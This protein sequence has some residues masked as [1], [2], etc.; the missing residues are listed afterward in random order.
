LPRSLVERKNYRL[1]EFDGAED[2]V[3]RETDADGLPHFDI[4]REFG[5]WT[6]VPDEIVEHTIHLEFLHLPE[7]KAV[8]RRHGPGM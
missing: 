1:V 8:A 3:L 4:V 7:F 5:T 6:D 2:A